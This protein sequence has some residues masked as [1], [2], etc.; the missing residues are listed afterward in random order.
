MLR[1][2]T[3]R[4]GIAAAQTATTLAQIAASI[5]RLDDESLLD[6]A[7]IFAHDAASPLQPLAAAEMTRRGLSL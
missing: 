1:L 5:G 7:D 3:K 6:L 4:Q 2:R